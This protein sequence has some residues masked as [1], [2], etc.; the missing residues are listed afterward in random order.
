MCSIHGGL[1]LYHPFKISR[2]VSS[3]IEMAFFLVSKIFISK[4]CLQLVFLDLLD[5]KNEQAREHE[6][7]DNRR[8]RADEDPNSQIK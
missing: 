1:E 6:N 2:A 8:H 5:I 3:V 7:E 4:P